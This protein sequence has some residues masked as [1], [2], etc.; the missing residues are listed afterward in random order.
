[1]SFLLAE[2]P[3]ARVLDLGVTDQRFNKARLVETAPGACF[4]FGT[5][6]HCWSSGET[7]TTTLATVESHKDGITIAD[8]PRPFQ[9]AIELF[10][11]L[12]IRYVWVDSLCIIQDSEADWQAQ[13]ALVDSI[14]ANSSLTIAI[15]DEGGCTPGCFLSEPPTVPSRLVRLPAGVD[16]QSRYS[17]SV[18]H[19]FEH[20]PLMRVGSLAAASVH[21]ERRETKRLLYVGRSELVWECKTCSIC[22]CGYRK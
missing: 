21:P 11:K 17:V 4:H 20:T 5:L 19:S 1:M 13:A 9:T 18:G 15:A 16:G 8:L 22:E 14:F 7:I 12:G 6:S 2:F 10:R 3:A